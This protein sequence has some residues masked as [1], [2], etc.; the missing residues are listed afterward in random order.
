MNEKLFSKTKLFCKVKPKLKEIRVF[1]E[2]EIF[3]IFLIVLFYFSFIE[4]SMSDEQ[5]IS[6]YYEKTEKCNFLMD[7]LNN[8]IKDEKRIE[9]EKIPS[10]L[11]EYTISNKYGKNMFCYNLKGS[12]YYSVRVTVSDD[13]SVE[14]IDYGFREET[15]LEEYIINYKQKINNNNENVRSIAIVLSIIIFVAISIVEIIVIF[16]DDKKM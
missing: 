14:N 4:T 5:I 8:V 10:D 13:W 12:D 1:F 3:F 15:S 2:L 9:I 16:D 7:I 11:V 6:S